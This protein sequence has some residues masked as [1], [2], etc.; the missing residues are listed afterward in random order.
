MFHTILVAVDPS[1]ARHSAIRMAAE[2]ARLTG[3]KVHVVHIAAT[4]LAWDT[5]VP[6]EEQ[7]EA[8]EVLREA[9]ATLREEGVGAQGEVIN[10]LTGRIPAAILQAA[11]EQQADLL[12]LSPHHRGAVAA[13]FNPRVS[14]AVAHA[15]QLAVLLAPEGP[16]PS[17]G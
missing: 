1:P 9:L 6:V 3:A 4:M 13:F 17:E 14:D 16:V 10:A 15:G 12:V 7:S 2:M 8:E 11:R 5:V